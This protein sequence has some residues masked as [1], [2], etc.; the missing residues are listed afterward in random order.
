[1]EKIKGIRLVRAL[2]LG[3]FVDYA[4]TGNPYAECCIQRECYL[5]GFIMVTVVTNITNTKKHQS[6]LKKWY[7]QSKTKRL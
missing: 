3:Y 1:M 5:I 2:G 4:D 6:L 7:E